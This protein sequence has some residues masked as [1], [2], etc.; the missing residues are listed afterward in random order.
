MIVCNTSHHVWTKQSPFLHVPYLHYS[1]LSHKWALYRHT[2]ITYINGTE[3]DKHAQSADI[4][5][6]NGTG[7]DLFTAV[8]LR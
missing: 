4:T 3:V 6:V 2:I 8:Y 5:H 7:L 1:S